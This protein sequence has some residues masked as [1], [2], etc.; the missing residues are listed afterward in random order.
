MIPHVLTSD[1]TFK[2]KIG[3]MAADRLPAVV[4]RSIYNKL[5]S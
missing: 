2:N 5:K 3:N 4:I 1:V